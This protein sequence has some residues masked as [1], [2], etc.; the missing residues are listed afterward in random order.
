[1]RFHGT[2]GRYS[3]RYGGESLRPFA[4]SYLASAR[5]GVPV[6][7]YFNNDLGGHAVRDALDLLALVGEDRPGVAAR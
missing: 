5:R 1:V 6:F 3:G 7:V 2:T 4:E